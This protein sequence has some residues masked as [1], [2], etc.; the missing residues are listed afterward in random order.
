MDRRAARCARARDRH[1][2]GEARASAAWSWTD[3]MAARCAC[4]RCPAAAARPR[5]DGLARGGGHGPCPAARGRRGTTRAA[6]RAR[7]PD[8]PGGLARRDRRK[9][10]R[11][12]LRNGDGGKS[13]RNRCRRRIGSVQAATAFASDSARSATDG[14]PPWR[15]A[16]KRPLAPAH[17]SAPSRPPA[18]TP[19]PA[20]PA[21]ADPDPVPRPDWP[22]TKAGEAAPHRLRRAAGAR[23]R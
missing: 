23:F 17:P 3:A 12:R 15:R 19:A 9:A 10:R 20:F 2:R 6:P 8:A 13:R 21:E 4:S 7:Y 1:R 11:R 5:H 22:A 18:E 14:M 16:L